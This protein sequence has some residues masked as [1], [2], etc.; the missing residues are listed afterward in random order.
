[1]NR[2]EDFICTPIELRLAKTTKFSWKSIWILFMFRMFL[3]LRMVYRNLY[4]PIG[5]WTHEITREK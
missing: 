2:V 1:M 5:Q 3:W 4:F